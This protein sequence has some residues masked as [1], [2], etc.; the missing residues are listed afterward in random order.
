MATSRTFSVFLAPWASSKTLGPGPW[1]SPSL[2]LDKMFN[3]VCLHHHW[4]LFFFSG[5]TFSSSGY[6]LWM[7]LSLKCPYCLEQWTVQNSYAWY[8]LSRLICWL[9]WIKPKLKLYLCS[10]CVFRGPASSSRLWFQDIPHYQQP[11]LRKKY[12]LHLR[13]LWPLHTRD[14]IKWS[15]PLKG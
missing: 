9:N 6:R 10:M 12:I 1:L 2:F 15:F 13:A 5:F 3:W 11:C 14:S 8:L 7:T 4:L